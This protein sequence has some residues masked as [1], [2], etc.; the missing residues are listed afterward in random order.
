MPQGGGTASVM[1]ITYQRLER[2]WW[3]EP[4]TVF[5]VLLTAVAIFFRGVAANGF[6]IYFGDSYDGLIEIS[7]LQHWYNVIA[8]GN[9]IAIT[10]YFYPYHDTVGYNDTYFVPGVFFTLARLIGADP[11]RAALAAHVAMKIIGFLG[12]YALLRLGLGI[13][14]A[15]ALAGAAVFATANASLLHMH[16]AQLLSVGL[17]AWLA[18]LALLLGKAIISHNK[19]A[20]AT[21]GC[22]LAILF[23]LTAFNS[24]YAAWFFAFFLILTLLVGIAIIAPINRR[25]WLTAISVSGTS[26]LLVAAVGIVSLTPLLLTYLP[27]IAEGAHH[28]WAT[29]TARFLLT[30]SSLINV[31]AGNLVWGKAFEGTIRGLT[32]HAPAGGEARFGFPLGLLAGVIVGTIWAARQ[33]TIAPLALTL[34]LALEITIV[35]MLKGPGDFSLWRLV[36]AI[37]PGANA[38]RVVSRLLLYAQVPVIMIVSIW[39]DGAQLPKWVLTA[40]IAFLLIEEVQLDPP[41]MLNRARELSML[42]GAGIPPPACRAF[43]VV[44][45]R[46]DVGAARLEAADISRAWNGEPPDILLDNYRH[47]VDAM[48]IAAYRNLPTI[49]GFSTFNPPDWEFARPDAPDYLERVARYAKR[50]DVA[51]LCGLDVR[52]TPHWFSFDLNGPTR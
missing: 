6:T 7:I 28:D 47:N 45:A 4:V 14:L 15:I 41:I 13:R 5:V 44:S 43:F 9:P 42:D 46:S 35:L 19:R 40:I 36:Y 18:L 12:M 29:E 31:G 37:V 30:P 3:L 38:V 20:V 26:L 27:K 34:G 24:F 50:H 25:Q 23:G 39:L 22:G 52:K 32:G 33:R 8:H 2:S 49:N 51:H 10:E 1:P 21:T 17:L 11:F 16:H 48:V